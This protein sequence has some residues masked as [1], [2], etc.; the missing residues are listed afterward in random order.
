MN[1]YMVNK[2]YIDYLR[3]FDT[4]VGYVEYGERLKL[5]IGVIFKIDGV[6]YYVPISS[7]KPNLIRL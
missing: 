2:T 5:H 3:Q 7:A 6:H 4:R 1:W